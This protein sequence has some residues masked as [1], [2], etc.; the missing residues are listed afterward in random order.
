MASP[1]RVEPTGAQRVELWA[2]RTSGTR[3]PTGLSAPRAATIATCSR[4][5]PKPVMLIVGDRGPCCW[6]IE[7]IA[8]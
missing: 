6:S 4:A 8:C 7:E 2:S 3:T 1:Y 5:L